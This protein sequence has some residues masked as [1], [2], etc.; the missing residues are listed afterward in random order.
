MGVMMMIEIREAVEDRKVELDLQAGQGVHQNMVPI[1]ILPIVTNVVDHVVGFLIR[2]V[3]VSID[4][5]AGSIGIGKIEMEHGHNPQLCIYHFLFVDFW[6]TLN[7]YIY[8]CVCKKSCVV[9][10]C[11]YK[12]I[13]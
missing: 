1:D 3:V 12:Y 4:H 9:I 10:I 5:L 8:V 7:H 2:V 6:D 11:L 13:I